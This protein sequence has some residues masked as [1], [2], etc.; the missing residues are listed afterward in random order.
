MFFRKAPWFLK[1]VVIAC[2]SW[3]VAAKESGLVLGLHVNADVGSPSKDT[4]TYAVWANAWAWEPAVFGKLTAFELEFPN[5]TSAAQI[6]KS[7]DGFQISRSADFSDLTAIPT[8]TYTMKV[9]GSIADTRTYQV[10]VFPQAL[11]GPISPEFV[12]SARETLSS[13]PLD[14]FTLA[15]PQSIAHAQY[16]VIS[17]ET[18]SSLLYSELRERPEGSGSVTLPLNLL[19]PGQAASFKVRYFNQYVFYFGG[20]EWL[21][22]QQTVTLDYETNYVVQ[23][24]AKG[25]PAARLANISARGFCGNGDRVTIGGFVIGGNAAKRVLVR[26]LGPTLTSYGLGQSEVLLDPNIEVYHGS[27]LIATNDNWADNANADE[28]D[29]TT[30]RIGAGK[31]SAGDATSSALLLTLAPGAYTFVASG[32]LGTSGIAL[33]EVYDADADT[34]GG[35]FVNIST[36]AYSTTGNGVAIGGFVVSGTAPKEVLLRAVGPTLTKFGIRQADVL[37]DPTIELHDASH[38]NVIIATNDNWSDS[39]VADEIKRTGARVGANAFDSE[40]T[41]SSALLIWLDPGVYTFVAAGKNGSSGIVL[42][43]AYD[44]D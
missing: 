7:E 13:A 43:E 5:G 35:R 37:A 16:A 40:D 17:L 8:G 25:Q 31:L 32:K 10:D 21:A 20:V 22:V 15:L 3:G 24:V 42:V 27:S 39:P 26:A 18:D 23:F 4:V 30:S 1:S 6:Y 29:A 28:I 2:L 9:T 34:N 14:S 12:A 36:R 33:L 44:A 41:R 11:P 19:Q 38:G